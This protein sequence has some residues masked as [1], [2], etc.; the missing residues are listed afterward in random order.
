MGQEARC[1][2][3][4]RDQTAEGKAL[5]ETDDLVSRSGTLR[6]KIPLREVQSVTARDGDLRIDFPDGFAVFALGDN[7]EKWAQK[8]LNPKTLLDK[9]GLKAGMAVSVLGVE[10]E[11][12]LADLRQ[13]TPDVS[14]G[15]AGSGSDLVFVAIDGPADLEQLSALK[16]AIKLDGA[17]WAVFRKGRKDFNENDVLRGGLG[18]GLVDVKVVRFSDTHTA[19]KFVIRKAERTGT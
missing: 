3:R 18:A 16:A 5:L 13:R 2:V 1:T 7:A 8:I 12:F 4:F 10:D 14:L 9:L 15:E 19:S 11:D 17:V 6:L